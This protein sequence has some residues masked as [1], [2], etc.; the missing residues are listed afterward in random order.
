MAMITEQTAHDR[1]IQTPISEIARYLQDTLSQR[2]TAVMIG[3]SDAKA[4]GKW[5]RG[6]RRPHPSAEKR[7]R[8][9]Y[10][11]A[12]LIGERGDATTIRAWF[13]GTNPYLGHKAPALVLGENP[14]EVM[15]AAREFLAN[16]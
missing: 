10:Q 13:R 9:A 2:T 16:G 4:V 8:D 3:V 14:T 5:A 1:A 6:E 12:E 11:V 7:L 15:R